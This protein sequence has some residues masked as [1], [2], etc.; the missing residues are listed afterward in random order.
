M[1]PLLL[2]DVVSYDSSQ[3]D[4]IA[5][6]SWVTEDQF[7]AGLA[8]VQASPGPM[9][10]FAA[11]LGAVMAQRA[12]KSVVAGALTC[13][14]GLFAPGVTLIFGV[15]PFWGY[16]RTFQ[17]YQKMLPGLNASAVGLVVAA[18]VQMFF[19]SQR[20]LAVS[21]IC[22]SHRYVDL[23]RNEVRE[24]AKS[25]IGR[26]TSASRRRWR[27]SGD[28][29]PGRLDAINQVVIAVVIFTIANSNDIL[30]IR[31]TISSTTSII[32]IN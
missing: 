4:N 27:S 21:K 1:L 31:P 8:L 6:N 10:N 26:F 23:I 16:I 2:D 20:K 15:L 12:G 13:W 18:A 32:I 7:F 9:F 11:Y 28:T 22:R 24:N 30:N 19:E 14:T 17:A 3:P 29:L 5:T 25:K